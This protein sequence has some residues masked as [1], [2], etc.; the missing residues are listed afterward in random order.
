MPDEVVMIKAIV[1]DMDGVLIDAKEWHYEALNK[2]L[3]LFGYSIGHGE[4]LTTYDGLPTSQ[5]LKLLSQGCGLPE[6]LHGFIS[7]LKQLYTAEQVIVRCKPRFVHQ[8]ALS[9]LK[10]RGYRLV[11][12]S[13]SIRATVDLMMDKS[14]LGQYLEFSLSNQDVAAPK[15]AP[16]IYVKAMQMLGVRSDECLVVEDNEHGIQAARAA[17]AHVFVVQNTDEV[18]LDNILNA[19]EKAEEGMK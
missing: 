2:A 14:D 8:Y 7:E 6:V 15:P 3:G 17:G 4:H 10:A 5:K 9:R 1:F 11:L 12:A 16:D 19:I 13:N 18:S